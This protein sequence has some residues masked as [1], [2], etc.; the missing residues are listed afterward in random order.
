M[1]WIKSQ[2]DWEQHVNALGQQFDPL[3]TVQ[4]LRFDAELLHREMQDLF[5][6]CPPIHWR[7]QPPGALYGLSL[8]YD[9]QALQHEWPFGSFGHSRY[10]QHTAADYFKVP[11]KER[12]HAPRGDYLDSLGFRKTLTEVEKLPALKA[13][14]DSFRMPVVRCTVRV[15]D[16]TQVWPTGNDSGGLHRDDSPFEVMRL[17]LCITSSPDFGLQY[18]G[19]APIS[20]RPGEHCVVNTDV[21]HRVWVGQR[22]DVQRMHLVIGLVPWLTYDPQ[23]DAW[24]PNAHFGNTHPYDLVRQGQIMRTP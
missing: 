9:P 22:S 6:L 23:N 21:D 20:L 12:R 11:E 8:S 3:L 4:G 16:G 13:L 15:L 14:L 10:Q 19:H 18:A 7:S 5:R 17:N 2:T 1:E 24:T